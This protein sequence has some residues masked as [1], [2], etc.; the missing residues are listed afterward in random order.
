MADI[1]LNG[2]PPVHSKPNRDQGREQQRKKKRSLK[3]QQKNEAARRDAERFGVVVTLSGSADDEKRE[4]QN[5]VTKR[6]LAQT[7]NLFGV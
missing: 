7:Y 2:V 3:D 1:T 6:S 5:R 4:D